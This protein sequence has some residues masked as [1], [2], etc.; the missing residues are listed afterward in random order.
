MYKS[1]YYT[2]NLDEK[3][4]ENNIIRIIF[5]LKIKLKQLKI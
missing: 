5:Y 4:K 2:I 3:N 1:C